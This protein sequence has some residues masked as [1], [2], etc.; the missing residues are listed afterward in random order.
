MHLLIATDLLN[1]SFTEVRVA[2][3]TV[4]LTETSLASICAVISH[5]AIS[6]SNP[7]SS[8]VLARDAV[9]REVRF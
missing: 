6:S 4:R 1:N 5:H 8:T 9:H 7:L 3:P 2:S